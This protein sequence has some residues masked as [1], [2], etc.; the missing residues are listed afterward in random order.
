MIKAIAFDFDGVLVESSNIKTDAFRR[1]FSDYPDKV[2]ELV[3]YH[4]KNMGIS[5]YVKFQYF[6][7]VLLK[8]S[9]TEYTGKTKTQAPRN[10]L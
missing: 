10:A 4:K 5:R 2:D 8:Q 6:Y 9:Y 3:E 7:E 1:L